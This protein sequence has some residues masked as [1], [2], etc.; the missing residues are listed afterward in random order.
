ME[1][2]IALPLVLDLLFNWHNQEIREMPEDP[3]AEWQCIDEVSIQHVD[4]VVYLT[5]KKEGY[6]DQSFITIDCQLKQAEVTSG[7]YRIDGLP[8]EV[9]E[10][11]RQTLR[12]HALPYPPDTCTMR[13]LSKK[14]FPSAVF[15]LLRKPSIPSLPQLAHIR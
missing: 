14:Y 3:T 10:Y 8:D 13:T 9:L 6:T 7:R 15:M 1:I 2:L 12:F 4:N 5:A 11:C